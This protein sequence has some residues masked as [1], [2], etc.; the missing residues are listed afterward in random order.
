MILVDHNKY[1]CLFIFF[2]N[3]KST[4]FLINRN[5]PTH[6]SRHAREL[7]TFVMHLIRPMGSYLVPNEANGYDNNGFHKYK[8][9][10]DDN[11]SLTQTRAIRYPSYKL[12]RHL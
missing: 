11:R 7:G 3:N 8:S 6:F 10:F 5:S 4:F 2:F 1:S 9:R 12:E